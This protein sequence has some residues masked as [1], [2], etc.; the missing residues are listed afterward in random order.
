[1]HG[2]LLDRMAWTRGLNRLLAAAGAGAALLCVAGPAHAILLDV[3]YF[4]QCDNTWGSDPLGDGTCGSTMCTEGCAV[5]SS[6]MLYQYYGGS[7]DPGQLNTCLT[8]NGGFA[9]GCLIIWSNSCMADGMSYAGSSGDIDA[10]LNAGRPVIAQVTSAQT[11]MHF[12]VIRGNDSG[13]YQ[14]NDPYWPNYTTI[15]QGGYTIQTIQRYSGSVSTPCAN[16]VTAQGETIIDDQDVCFARH[17][18][19]WWEVSSGYN[20]HHYYTYAGDTPAPD[21]WGEWK[22]GVQDAGTYQVSVYLPSDHPSSVQA[23]YVVTHNGSDESRIIDQTSASGWVVLGSYDFASGDGQRVVLNDNS[24]ELLADHIPV[25]FD[26]VKL[27][28]EVGPGGAG[29]SGGTGT[30]ATGGSGATGNTGGTG[31]SGGT[32]GTSAAGANAGVPS[33]DTGCGCRV[34][35][36]GRERPSALWLGLG[37]AG[38]GLRRRR[39]G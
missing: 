22:F 14:I 19:W 31:A 23:P 39:R 10:E 34:G 1:M 3:P 16:T 17:G 11:S 30:G 15:S 26:A 20:D 25:R 35:A 21:C 38:L 2:T 9:G 5:T 6:A 28:P 27:T 24:G 36:S 4:N 37:L 32:G 18:S 7:M 13:E 29:G 12:V 33:E 8:A